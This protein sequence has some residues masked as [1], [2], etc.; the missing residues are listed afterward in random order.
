MTCLHRLAKKLCEEW[1]TISLRQDM[2]RS[3]IVHID[4]VRVNDHVPFRTL[5]NKILPH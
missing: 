4:L 5:K 3:N 2:F 1:A